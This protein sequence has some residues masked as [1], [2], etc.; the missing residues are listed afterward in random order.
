M[1]VRSGEQFETIA[2]KMTIKLH[3]Q[4]AQ[5][6]IMG[7]NKARQRSLIAVAERRVA[8]RLQPGV[9]VVKSN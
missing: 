2:H 8:R 1:S 7:W 5:S 9:V 3:Q 4:A 6:Q